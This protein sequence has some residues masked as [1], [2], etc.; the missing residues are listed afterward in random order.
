MVSKLCTK[1]IITLNSGSQ[2]K[3]TVSGIDLKMLRD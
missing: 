3:M 1:A 2:F